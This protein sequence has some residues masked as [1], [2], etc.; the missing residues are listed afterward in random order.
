MLNGINK[1][2]YKSTLPGIDYGGSIYRVLANDNTVR[3]IEGF[4]P[5]YIAVVAHF[6]IG[7]V[8]DLKI[9]SNMN[10]LSKT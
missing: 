3:S 2:Q 8:N 4:A 5:I 1:Q 6:M 10:L 9:V 7:G